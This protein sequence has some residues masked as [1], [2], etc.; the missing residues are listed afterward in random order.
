MKL[1]EVIFIGYCVF[2]MSAC[3]S[4]NTLFEKIS[5]SH[6]GITTDVSIGRY[7]ALNGL[8]L[9]GDV[10]GDFHPCQ[11]SRAVYTFPAMERRW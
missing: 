8:L 2:G 10:R 11:F 7:D 9:K 3:S 6:S 1:S 4:K 5:S